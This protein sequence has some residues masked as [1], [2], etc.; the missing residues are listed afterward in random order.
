[1]VLTPRISGSNVVPTGGGRFADVGTLLDVEASPVNEPNQTRSLI[2]EGESEFQYDQ[3]QSKEHA[4]QK[5]AYSWHRNSRDSRGS[6]GQ[7][8]ERQFNKSMLQNSSESFASAFDERG[9]AS[10]QANSSLTEYRY[11][12]SL[13][14]IINTYEQTAQVIHGKII[15]TGLNFTLVL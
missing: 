5:Q 11:K 8:T 9:Q 13:S 15:P 12:V 2:Y 10:Q 3:F 1:M 14:T 6:F 7:S 4:S